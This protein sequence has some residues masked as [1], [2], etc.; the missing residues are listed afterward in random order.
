PGPLSEQR[1]SHRPV[2]PSTGRSRSPASWTGRHAC[3]HGYGPSP[4]GRIL[5]PAWMAIF[6][7]ARP[8]AHVR[9][10]LFPARVTSWLGNRCIT[11]TLADAPQAFGNS[12][13]SL[14][15]KGGLAALGQG[16]RRGT[17]SHIPG[18]N[19]E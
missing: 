10:S 3:P 16:R 2:S 9:E 13:R 6:P 17:L 4:R 5:Q 8:G 11:R 15:G 7:A 1:G 14:S 19:S 18:D 12:L